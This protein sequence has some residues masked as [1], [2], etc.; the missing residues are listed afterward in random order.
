MVSNKFFLDDERWEQRVIHSP[1][2]GYLILDQSTYEQNIKIMNDIVSIRMTNA[3]NSRVPYVI[4][5]VIKYKYIVQSY[6]NIC[7]F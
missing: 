4:E 2:A 6:D 5:R 3:M 1:L 7:L